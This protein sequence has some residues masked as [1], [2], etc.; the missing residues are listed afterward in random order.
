MKENK[1]FNDYHETRVRRKQLEIEE[2]ITDLRAEG[3]ADDVTAE[4]L[5]AHSELKQYAEAIKRRQ[6]KF[7]MIDVAE[8]V[9]DNKMLINKV[10]DVLQQKHSADDGSKMNEFFYRKKT[11]VSQFGKS[12]E[13][14][15]E[16]SMS[17]TGISES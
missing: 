1:I 15:G 2:G 4:E 8:L 5:E 17:M 14:V 11:L 13:G 12:G 6:E 16:G 3:F 7:K 10:D 9:V